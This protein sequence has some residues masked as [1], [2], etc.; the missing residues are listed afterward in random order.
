MK[1]ACLV[2]ACLMVSS[3]LLVNLQNIQATQA[4]AE[5]TWQTLQS[6]P[7]P[8]SGIAVTVD[9]KIY[10][11]YGPN[12]FEY[13]PQTQNLTQKTTM[14]TQRGGYGL[15][16]VDYKIYTI[17]GQGGAAPTNINEVYD[18]RTGT[19]ETKQPAI[20]Y[21]SELIA[22]AVNGKI[23][24]MY[25]GGRYDVSNMISTGS[26]ID[27]YDPETDNWTRISALPQEVSYPS[28]SCAIDDK[29]YIIKDST[30][31][32]YY[33][34]TIG[35]GKLHIYDTTTDTWSTGATLPTFYKLCRV[36][37]TAGERAPK[38]I[39][40]V[41]GEVIARSFGDFDCFN[42]TFSYD[43]LSDCWSRAADMS[44]ARQSAAVAVVDDKIYALGGKIQAYW[45][46]PS[47]TGAV[48]VY[49]PFGYV[50][51]QPSASPS[52]SPESPQQ[53]ALPE[54]TAVIVGAVIAGAVIA[55]TAILVYY[56]KRLKTAKQNKPN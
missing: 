32:D 24:A 11:F 41:G 50:T 39:Y 3:M 52:N 8:L 33:T 26:N 19:W 53:P 12:V 28:Y 44:T 21:S 38:R 51:E 9:E 31:D 4:T 18:T 45:L 46:D 49:T 13:D 16:A 37:A 55:A 40:L 10:I 2:L 56:H 5:N 34:Y 43:P 29:I 48:E 7:E 36:V 15:A 35:E 42:A 1:L 22:N 14:P 20:D 25:S 54:A 27:V 47:Q 23:Y 17:G 30:G 6:L